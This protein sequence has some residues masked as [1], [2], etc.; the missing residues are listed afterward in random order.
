MCPL[1]QD[2][3][4]DLCRPERGGGV[5]SEIGVAHARGEDDDASL[6]QVAKGAAADVR[7]GH[8][9]H[10]DGRQHPR[11]LARTLDGVLQSEG[12]DDRGQHAHGVRR[13]AVETLSLADGAP[14]DVAPA[15]HDGELEIELGTSQGDLAGK[16]LDDAAID[17]LVRRRGRQRLSRHLEHDAATMQRAGRSGRVDYRR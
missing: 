6:V 2:F 16:A 5:G 9:G 15:H 11:G 13:G 17:R 4:L 8:F 14:P 7:L 12:V 10:R 3:G 1:Q